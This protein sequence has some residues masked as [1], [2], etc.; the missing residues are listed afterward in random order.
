MVRLGFQVSRWIRTVVTEAMNEDQ[1]SSW[2]T[3][4]LVETYEHIED[5]FHP[6]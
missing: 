1:D 6:S 4:S 3:F 2:G 5:L